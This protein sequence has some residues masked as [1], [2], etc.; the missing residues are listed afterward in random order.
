[1]SLMPQQVPAAAALIRAGV[2]ATVAG[3][4]RYRLEPEAWADLRDRL[5]S[6][7][8]PLLDLWAEADLVHALFLEPGQR[9]LLAS[10]PIVARRFLAL[11]PVREA[12]A[13]AERIVR[14]LWGVEAIEALDLR[15]WLDHGL[16]G[17][18]A[19][20]A[21]RPG[22]SAWPPEPPE[23]VEP[24]EPE[25]ESGVFQLGLGPV[26]TL[27]AG[28]VHLRL[29]LDGDRIARLET[30]LGYAHRGIVRLVRDRSPA[31]AAPLV[32]RIDAGATVAHQAAFAR[33][34]EAARGWRITARAEALRIVMGEL[35]RMAM[36][37]HR[38]GQMAELAVLEAAAEQAVRLRETLLAATGAAF[39][40]RLLLDAIVPGGL[41]C[42]PVEAGLVA[43]LA[44]LDRLEARLPGLER[45]LRLRRVLVSRFGGRAVLP[46]ESEAV[47]GGRDAGTRLRTRLDGIR[48]SLTQV[49]QRLMVDPAGPV[50]GDAPPADLFEPSIEAMAGADGPEGQVWHWIRL[51]GGR[52][53]ALHVADPSLARFRLLEQAAIGLEPDE[54]PLLCASLGLSVSGADQ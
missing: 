15:P 1:M 36:H 35:E 49:R 31:E 54:L 16:W 2:P 46:S 41:A 18:T 33:A 19:P 23:F 9:P 50:Q 4:P 22:P 6:D 52:L 28:P 5:R 25:Q 17:L 29:T 20:L 43:L 34:V 47:A 8:L 53:S 13:P 37:L 39:G 7:P 21:T 27:V 32:A 24:G 45:A 30:R 10:V 26:Q 14:D 11:S 51:E 42:A 40:H 48:T 38:I 3:A 12:I 44:A